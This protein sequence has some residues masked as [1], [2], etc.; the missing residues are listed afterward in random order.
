MLHRLLELSNTCALTRTAEGP[1]TGGSTNSR[2]AGLIGL[3]RLRASSH[4]IQL[5]S[6]RT[7]VDCMWYEQTRAR[8]HFPHSVDTLKSHPSTRQRTRRSAS[9]DIAL[10]NPGGSA[11][12]P[13]SW[14]RPCL[15][16]RETALLH[17]STR[18]LGGVLRSCEGRKKPS[19]R[20]SESLVEI[21]LLPY[22]P[23]S[24][25]GRGSGE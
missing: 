14:T 4:L 2:V 12:L 11:E 22:R 21:S 3:R 8:L 1:T 16:S 6:T 10:R 5:P 9:P 20:V 18:R 24:G 23:R 25:A 15:R 17:L 13:P 7:A 19:L